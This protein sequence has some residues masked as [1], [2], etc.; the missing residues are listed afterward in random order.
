MKAEGMVAVVTGSGSGLG[1]ATCKAL[2]EAGAR[3]LCLDL[4]EAGL[5]SV[6]RSLGQS[7]IARKVDVSE[8]DS[9]RDA[10]DLAVATFGGL[11]IAVNCA[12]VGD[13]AKTISRGGP[14]PFQWWK[15][16][17]DFNLTGIF[18]VLRYAALAVEQNKP[19]Q[20]TGKRG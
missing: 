1:L 16:S 14:F 5:Q 15:K 13:A 6:A 18:N 10:V 4:N 17:I 3:V 12:G 8:E 7:V 9:V 20:P 11:H 2:V 19:E